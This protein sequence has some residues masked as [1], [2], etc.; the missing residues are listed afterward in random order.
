MRHLHHGFSAE[1]RRVFMLNCARA[2]FG[3]SVGA[4]IPGDL[5]AATPT[6]A[7]AKSGKE[8]KNGFGKTKR[9]IFIAPRGGMSHIDSFDPKPGAG[10][11]PGNPIST[12]GDFQVTSFFPETAKV[13]KN[14][15]LIRS[16]SAK[17]AIHAPAAYLMRTG[18][19]EMGGVK[20]PIAGAWA[21]SYLGPSHKIMPSSVAL[22]RRSDQGHGFFP[23]TH[24]PLA[25][26]DPM[27]GLA[28]AK[29]VCSPQEFQKRNDLLN[30]LDADFRKKTTD[31]EVKNYTDYY[32]GATEL[33]KSTSELDSFDLTKEPKEMQEKY[34]SSRF[35]QAALLAR[36]LIEA[37]TRFVEIEM[38]EWDH[39]KNLAKDFEE[40]AADLDHVYATLINDLQQ[41]GMLE[42][43]MVVIASEFGR[44]PSIGSGRNH[45]PACFTTVLAG[46]GVKGGFAYSSSDEQ[47]AKPVDN[48]TTVS[49]FHA[50]LGWAFG[51][52]LDYQVTGT[53]GRTYVLA[54][55]GK[56]AV[57][58][59]A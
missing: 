48:P 15:C 59:F 11:G 46:G 52:P 34:G 54:S 25:I 50:T 17:I 56:P 21:Q 26:G 53:N 18:F 27:D 4:A 45:Y 24:A 58:V 9:M 16:M 39:H 22:N 40:Q 35:G 7:V 8:V 30:L 1:S 19:T 41:R 36:R 32:T 10:K 14:L 23:V 57:G 20:H 33:M 6:P 29:A 37:G 3:L 43:T 5:L 12:T 44:S 38:G 2:A 13:A 47:G 31:I 55:R 51:L 49:D 28:N 42:S